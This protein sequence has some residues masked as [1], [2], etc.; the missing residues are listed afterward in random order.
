MGLRGRKA[1]VIGRL[2]VNMFLPHNP[3]KVMKI[4]EDHVAGKTPNLDH[5]LYSRSAAKALYD[6]GEVVYRYVPVVAQLGIDR[7]ALFGI[8]G[9]KKDSTVPEN[10]PAK[11]GEHFPGGTI[12]RY[13][14]FHNVNI[15]KNCDI[16]P[17]SIVEISGDNYIV[18]TTGQDA[19]PAPFCI[20]G[21]KTGNYAANIRTLKSLSYD[22]LTTESGRKVNAS[23][24]KT[25]VGQIN[26]KP[27]ML[28]LEDGG[29]IVHLPNQVITWG[30]LMK[31][32][33][34]LTPSQ[35]RNMKDYSGVAFVALTER[36]VGRGVT[37]KEFM[38]DV[39]DEMKA[40]S[41]VETDS[42]KIS[43]Y[44]RFM[45]RAGHSKDEN[46]K[47]D[48]KDAIW[49]NISTVQTRNSPT[50]VHCYGYRYAAIGQAIG[51]TVNPEGEE[52]VFILLG[53][54][55]THGLTKNK[56]DLRREE[57]A[58]K[59]SQDVKQETTDSPVN[60]ETTIDATIEAEPT[61]E[62]QVVSEVSE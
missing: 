41:I 18:G 16:E 53:G 55:L 17:D 20:D 33:K 47:M 14:L 9:N 26:S 30:H 56:W 45:N 29:K 2:F 59:E 25:I 58:K 60:S 35:I 8:E 42:G 1:K 27:V 12:G 28:T 4:A 22:K 39:I 5:A 37:R 13:R 46:K 23:E 31:E 3:D 36:W 50:A 51:R 54:H 10:W 38:S 11:F 49:N 21:S 52:E 7:G 48:K 44:H 24:V 19:I 62:T 15:F 32:G 43:L 6:N 57:K 34:A 40:S 61:V